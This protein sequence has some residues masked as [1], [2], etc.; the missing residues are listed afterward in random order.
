MNGLTFKRP[1]IWPT[2]VKTMVMSTDAAT[3][4]IHADLAAQ[5]LATL[6]GEETRCYFL[7]RPVP[8]SS[9]RSKWRLGEAPGKQ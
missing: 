4:Q 9:R 7:G 5:G 8:G 1:N 6:E 2:K 3:K